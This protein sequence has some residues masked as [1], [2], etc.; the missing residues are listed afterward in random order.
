M[1]AKKKA[2]YK[3]LQVYNDQTRPPLVEYYI[4]WATQSNSANKVKAPAHHKLSGTGSVECI[5]ASIFEV[6][7]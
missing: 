7:N 4:T 3:Y 2:V 5:N 6:L 1:M